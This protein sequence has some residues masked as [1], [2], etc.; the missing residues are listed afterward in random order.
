M[1]I[2]TEDT[3]AVTEP[4]GFG[5]APGYE[6]ESAP[7]R[8]AA[9]LRHAPAERVPWVTAPAVWT[10]AEIL[11]ACHVD[12]M[13]PGLVTALAASWAYARYSRRA[14]RSEHLELDGPEVA[15]AVA[16]P[17]AWLTLAARLG[18]LPL[19]GSVTHDMISA[20]FALMYSF[21]PIWLRRHDAVRSARLRRDDAAQAE[22]ARIAERLA[23][24]AKKREWHRLAAKIRLQGSDLLTAAE[25]Q[26][27]SETWEIDT[28]G[29]ETLA[30]EVNAT[31]AAHVLSG[32]KPEAL[33]SRKVPMDRVEVRAHPEYAYHLLVTFSRRPRF[34]PGAAESLAWHPLASGEL[35]RDLP[36]AEWFTSDSPSIRDPICIGIDPETG[37]PMLIVLFDDVGAHRV[38][39]LGT[40]GSGKSTVLNT[41]RERLTACRD[42]VPLQINLSKATEE[43]WWVDLAAASALT[44]NEAARNKALMML[45]FVHDVVNGGRPRAPG[46]DNHEPTPGEP[47][48]ALILDEVDKTADDDERK[49]Q[50]GIIASKCRSEGIILIIGSQRPQDMYVGGGM[51]RSNL[52]DIIWGVLRSNDLRQASGGLASL[53]DMNE[54]GRGAPGV[55]G[56]AKFPMREGAPIQRGRAF[57]WG[58]PATGLISIIEAR[59]AAAGGRRPMQVLDQ[60]LAPRFGAQWAE[61]TGAATGAD[62]DAVT[63]RLAAQGADP[64]R[65]SQ[66]QTRNGSVPSGEARQNRLTAIG[67]TIRGLFGDDDQ[68]DDDQPQTAPARPSAT[69]PGA[70]PGASAG[71]LPPEDQAK[72]WDLLHSTPGGISTRRP[73]N[74]GKLRRADPL[75][76][77]EEWSE[78]SVRR[79]LSIW[80]ADG[81]A[82]LA[83]RGRDQRWLPARLRVVADVPGD[84]AGD[85]G[86]PGADAD[87][88]FDGEFTEHE[89]VMIA[90]SWIVLD[91]DGQGL[92]NARGQLG[93]RVVSQALDLIRHDPEYVTAELDRIVSG[94]RNPVRVL[95]A[96]PAG[97]DPDD[98][99]DGDDGDEPDWCLDG[100]GT[101]DED[102]A[103]DAGAAP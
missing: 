51:V 18:P 44:D 28:Y 99:D 55:F 37:E 83:G 3:A 40:S 42:V 22:A 92:A 14:A 32:Q 87:P 71:P 95:R 69:G 85:P 97:D 89:L 63:S 50:L 90:A 23:L 21:G 78:E 81:K 29:A 75:P 61:I 20:T 11:H 47:A 101:E 39:V 70:D 53:P 74:G 82:R 16:A 84:Q 30:G 6:P 91:H 46:Y 52:T 60:G 48:L 4:Q 67:D 93:E 35:N 98:G 8:G 26:N 76:G 25:N 77:N 38:L 103:A 34:T 15:A 19:F 62:H 31:W 57:F 64:D 41:I 54:Y 96:P 58:K 17:G 5:P 12:W 36:G 100:D 79:Q 27:D 43:K 86:Q 13:A 80:R 68:G 88:E 94:A 66:R 7:A 33:G 10:A 9:W 73:D 24:L 56:V 49:R 72:L 59:S 2:D 45:D 102:D 65:Y 1:T